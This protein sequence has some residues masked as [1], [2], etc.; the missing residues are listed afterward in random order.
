MNFNNLINLQTNF[1]SFN[2]QVKEVM[3]DV[4]ARQ[5]DLFFERAVYQAKNNLEYSSIADAEYALSLAQYT[6][7]D[8]PIVYLIGF[9][10][11]AHIFTNKIKKAKAYYNLGIQLLDK[12]AEDYELDRASF[13]I[14]KDLLNGEDWKENLE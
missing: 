3:G 9:L 14:L 12:N 13:D 10:C 1:L 4:F 2:H 7:D 8:Y 11:E 5:A 6:K